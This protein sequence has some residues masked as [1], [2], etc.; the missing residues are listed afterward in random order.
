MWENTDENNSEYRNVSHSGN[1]TIQ[2][3]IKD[4]HLTKFYLY[5]PELLKTSAICP[6]LPIMFITLATSFSFYNRP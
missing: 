1:S 3:L 6:G 5:F 4:T 2:Y